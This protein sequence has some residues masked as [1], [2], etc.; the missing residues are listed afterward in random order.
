[1]QEGDL[2]RE[3]SVGIATEL[4]AGRSGDPIPVEVLYST[5]VQ[6]GP[7][8]NSTS[9]TMGT[10]SFLGGISAG[11]PYSAMI[12]ER[13]E[14]CLYSQSGPSWPVLGRPLPSLEV[15][16]PRRDT[17]RYQMKEKRHLGQ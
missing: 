9:C 10:G 14:P 17:F 8:A 3:S 5:S 1:V 12:K 4:R 15:N 6:T 2:G 7:E 11:A 13:V 16:S